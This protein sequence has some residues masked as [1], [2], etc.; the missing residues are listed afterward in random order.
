MFRSKDVYF[1]KMRVF[2]GRRCISKNVRAYHK[3]ILPTDPHSNEF[4]KDGVVYEP[5]SREHLDH[6]AVKGN[7]NRA[8]IILK[9]QRRY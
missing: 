5:H 2:K 8:K 7:S 3:Y 9:G 1:E 6:R 4:V